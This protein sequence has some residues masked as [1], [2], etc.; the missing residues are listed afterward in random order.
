MKMFRSV[1]NLLVITIIGLTLCAL[2]V[3]EA[4]AQSSTRGNSSAL[5]DHAPR[6]AEE[7]ATGVFYDSDGYAVQ[8]RKTET[9]GVN[10]LSADFLYLIMMLGIGAFMGRIIKYQKK[11]PDTWV[12]I[13][14]S[15][16]MIGATIMAIMGSKKRIHA[17]EYKIEVRQ[18]GTVNNMQADAIREQIKS[19]RELE[20]LAGK[21]WKI[22][23]AGAA[24]YFGAAGYAY[25]LYM[26]EQAGL[27]A[28]STSLQTAQ[29]TFAATCSPLNPESCRQAAACANAHAHLATL[30]TTINAP[31][32]PSEAMAGAVEGASMSAVAAT[33]M[34]LPASTVCS[35]VITGSVVPNLTAGNPSVIDAPVG[36]FAPPSIDAEVLKFV[37]QS[38]HHK[39][40]ESE[41]Q[42]QSPYQNLFYSIKPEV[43]KQGL[44]VLSSQFETFE[45][46]RFEQGAL[47]S[48]DLNQLKHYVSLSQSLSYARL[49]HINAKNQS[50]LKGLIT[51][52]FISSAHAW[53]AK[54]FGLA[55]GAA[56]AYYTSSRSTAVW[57]D[58]FLATPKWRAIVF[59]I[60]GTV[61]A[62][63]SLISKKT[64]GTMG[65]N[66]KKLEDLLADV[67]R[68][69]TGARAFVAPSQ[70]SP[71]VQRGLSPTQI[72]SP[73]LNTDLAKQPC[74]KDGKNCA[75]LES[76][77]TSNP[78]LTD[79][80]TTMSNLA[81]LSGKVADG[82]MGSGDLSA[83]TLGDI[84]ALAAKQGVA[85]QLTSRAAEAMNK[86][87]KEAG[88]EPV[89]L[90][91]VTDS[92]L[93]SL[94]AATIRSLNADPNAR[95]ALASSFGVEPL[96]IPG[97]GNAAVAGIDREVVESALAAGGGPTGVGSAAP[98]GFD[99]NFDFDDGLGNY[100]GDFTSAMLGSDGMIHVDD[101]EAID[102]IVSNRDV[103]LFQIITVR[104]FKSGYPRLFEIN[105]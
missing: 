70:Q 39:L 40:W 33:N 81:S 103:S 19:Y 44:F 94:Q 83:A 102:D 92:A 58:S 63:S 76:Q 27:T 100:D 101:Y 71:G 37:E 66:A 84:D 4:R 7:S 67:M 89:D 18:D 45:Q 72:Q 47:S 75:K 48:L 1:L 85:R 90:Q 16:I 20:S 91:A 34:C 105:E 11:S 2:P 42:F 64:E 6:S 38:Q 49:E 99:F 74:I 25:M 5:P 15:V 97:S 61:A 41:L 87:L 51:E 26:Q 31:P 68:L 65:E 21:K 8:A 59:G 28:C 80:G 82:M 55:G 54:E 98:G 46:K 57:L 52:H 13:A 9:K 35:S 14:A 73:N 30:H 17:G 79:F 78:G 53:G 23:A 32:A 22:E 29:M 60:A 3:G 93:R 86:R 104:Y 96:A 95:D 77:I 10:D 36:N 88:R 24:A 12:A 50:L 56:L 69:Q 43:Y 62:A